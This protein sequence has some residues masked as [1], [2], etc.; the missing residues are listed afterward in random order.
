M[1]LYA[2]LKMTT[3]N[4]AIFSVLAT[5]PKLVLLGTCQDVGLK[6]VFKWCD[7]IEKKVKIM[8]LLHWGYFKL[9]LSPRPKQPQFTGTILSI[10]VFHVNLMQRLFV[11]FQSIIYFVLLLLL[12][13]SFITVLGCFMCER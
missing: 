2:I 9:S 7:H 10:F 8:G 3:W 12:V 6:C 11:C 5:R 4:L 13:I 1:R